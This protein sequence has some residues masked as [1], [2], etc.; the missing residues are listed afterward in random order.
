MY[1]VALI[2][3]GNI[4]F[5]FDKHPHT[6]TALSHAKGIFLNENFDLKYVSDI[7]D[8][9]LKDLKKLFTNVEYVSDYTLLRTCSDIDVLVIATPTAT[10]KDIL[11]A[12]QGST[13]IQCFFI[14]KPL[15]VYQKDYENIP[16]HVKEKIIVNYPRRFEPNFQKISKDI[17]NNV[18][19]PLKKVDIHYSKGFSNNGSHAID[20]LYFMLG[21]FSLCHSTIFDTTTGFNQDDLTLDIFAK[22][23]VGENE[24]NLYFLGFDYQHLTKFSFEFF[25]EKAV[26]KYDDTKASATITQI[27]ADELYPEYLVASNDVQKHDILMDKIMLFAYDDLLNRLNKKQSYACSFSEELNNTKFKNMILRK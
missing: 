9:H 11:V 17:Q 19:G 23:T 22:I 5:L 10:H 24:A 16:L 15:F 8:V 2:G 18:Y 1:N 21:N 4:G 27:K 7:N 3:M 25:F 6:P 13:N 14:E 20:Y 26:L 12:F